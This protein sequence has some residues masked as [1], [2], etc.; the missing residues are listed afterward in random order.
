MIQQNKQ[1]KM[2]A[3]IIRQPLYVFPLKSNYSIVE[4]QTYAVTSNFSDFLM[5]LKPP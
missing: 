5:A 2:A 1:N 3:E 4:G